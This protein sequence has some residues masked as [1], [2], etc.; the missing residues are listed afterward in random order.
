M[1]ICSYD[2]LYGLYMICTLNYCSNYVFLKLLLM[3]FEFAFSVDWC[4]EEVMLL[5]CVGETRYEGMKKVCA[6]LVN[7]C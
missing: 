2:N 5:V 1:C 6:V 3:T 4:I 7:H